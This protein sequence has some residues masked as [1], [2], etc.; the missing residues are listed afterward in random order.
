MEKQFIFWI[1]LIQITARS[2]SNKL[3]LLHQL[4]FISVL[5]IDGGDANPENSGSGC[6]MPLSCIQMNTAQTDCSDNERR[7]P[8]YYYNNET[9][10]CTKLNTCNASPQ[11]GHTS[12]DDCTSS[13]GIGK[14]MIMISL[15]ITI[16]C[17]FQLYRLALRYLV[18]TRHL[19][20]IY[21]YLILAL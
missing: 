2:K 6:I 10:T 9:N 8:R 20:N 16:V 21:V 4:T 15:I 1:I 12:M 11:D 13:C 7:Q 18:L 3:S 5:I 19:I 17:M 14:L